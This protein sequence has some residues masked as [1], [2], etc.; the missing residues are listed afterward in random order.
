M[1]EAAAAVAVAGDRCRMA[2]DWSDTAIHSLRH[3]WVAAA[4]AVVSA[5]L[6]VVWQS[7]QTGLRLASPVAWAFELD[8]K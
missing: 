4:A 3:T 5:G 8:L 7:P 6:I 2:V 1:E